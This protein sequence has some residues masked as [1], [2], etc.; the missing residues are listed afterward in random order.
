MN[1]PANVKWIWLSSM[2]SCQSH[3][4]WKISPFF[5]HV[6]F[7]YCLTVCNYFFSYTSF[8][9]IFTFY[10]SLYF[11]FLLSCISFFTF[12][13]P[14]LITLLFCL[15]FSPSRHLKCFGLFS[16]L[17]LKVFLSPFTYF[18]FLPYLFVSPCLLI[19]FLFYFIF[20]PLFAVIL[21]HSLF[22]F[23]SLLFSFLLFFLYSV[24]LFR[25]VSKAVAESDY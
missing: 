20:S 22:F 4:S 2:K 3:F 13:T 21:Y 14:H 24:I 19:Y 18:Y 16:S 11:C 9:L 25:S 23:R 6:S 8:R 12:F 7:S 10:P 15:W 17:G 5:F 1:R